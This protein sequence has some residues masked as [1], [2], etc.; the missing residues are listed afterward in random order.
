MLA[1]LENRVDSVTRRGK[2][3]RHNY[4]AEKE[5]SGNERPP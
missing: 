1:V 3:P 5:K 2:S 4:H